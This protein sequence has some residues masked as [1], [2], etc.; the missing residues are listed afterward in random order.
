MEQPS[1]AWRP[2]AIV[3]REAATPDLE[4]TTAFYE[5]LLG[6]TP[7]YADLH[8]HAPGREPAAPAMNHTAPHAEQNTQ[9]TLP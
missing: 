9:E 7:P 5:A 3:W 2:G 6:W 8:A 1:G 4:R